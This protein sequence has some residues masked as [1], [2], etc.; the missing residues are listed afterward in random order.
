MK[1]Y[2]KYK[3]TKIEWH[4]AVPY[5]WTLKKL[6]QVALIR[7]S[8]VDRHI[9]ESEVQVK[10]LH[11]PD[12]YKNEI[13]K[14]SYKFKK[15]SCSDTEHE[16]FYLRKGD[17][18]ITKDSEKPDDIAVPCYISEDLDNVVSGYHLTIITPDTELIDGAFLLRYLQ[19]QGSRNYFEIEANGI[20]RF[21]LGQRSIFNY[22]VL[23]PP[24]CEQKAI[25]K[26]L[27][28]KTTLID[29][30]IEKTKKK[31]A[32]LHEQ[33]TAIINQA[34]TKGLDPKAK[35]KDSGV[36]WIGEIPESWTRKRLSTISCKIGDGI[37]STP[38][39]IDKSN[40]K[41][42]NGNNLND[43]VIRIAS[44]TKS[45]SKIEF[46]KHKIELNDR[47]ILYSING[48]I[49]NIAYYKSEK[50]ILGKSACYLVLNDCVDLK[51]VFYTLKSS[52]L[53][54]YFKFHLTGS[55]IKNLSLETIRKAWISF[56]PLDQQRIISDFIEKK[57]TLYNQLIGKEEKRNTLLKEYRQALISEVITGKI[58][59][60]DEIPTA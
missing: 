13:I 32:L 21:G 58:C 26:Y 47:T 2:K 34:V 50:V 42:I 27:D 22:P 19:F 9:F 45:V 40:Y 14:A 33:R 60:L 38:K 5:N 37:H 25:A 48:T 46:E 24:I 3:A 53:K 41:F 4:T 31:I 1:K 56:P 11:Y 39:Y 55:T 16:K 23:L 49:G 52:Y 36:E 15:G 54:E 12:C 18:V 51:F 29:S 8:S 44:L 57:N 28:T 43:G 6:K 20:T 10:V 7:N 17:V 59:V 35:M 30:L